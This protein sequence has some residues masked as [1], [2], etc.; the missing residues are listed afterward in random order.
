MHCH[1]RTLK[2]ECHAGIK[3]GLSGDCQHLEIKKIDHIHNHEVSE[4]SC[5]IPTIFIDT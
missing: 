5:M 4:V 2:R 3:I 1:F